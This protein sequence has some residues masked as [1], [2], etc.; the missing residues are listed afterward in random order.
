MIT[1]RMK[2]ELE[3]KKKEFFLT[4]IHLSFLNLSFS[5]RG[6]LPITRIRAITNRLPSFTQ[7]SFFFFLLTQLFHQLGTILNQSKLFLFL[8]PRISSQQRFSSS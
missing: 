5:H 6:N 7:F 4:A 1:V 2:R 3:K 8:P